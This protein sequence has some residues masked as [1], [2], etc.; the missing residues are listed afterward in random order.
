MD[1]GCFLWQ[2]AWH[3]ES[4]RY[5]AVWLCFSVKGYLLI[6]VSF[7]LPDKGTH[8]VLTMMFPPLLLSLLPF[9]FLWTMTKNTNAESKIMSR[10]PKKHR[11]VSYIGKCESVTLFTC[12]KYSRFCPY[13]EKDNTPTALL[14]WLIK[15]D[16]QLILKLHAAVSTLLKHSTPLLFAL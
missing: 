16:T 3:T 11:Y 9:Q 5:F 12:T 6:R 13:P 14:T 4:E 7:W 2:Q 15:I 8:P 1:P 10:L